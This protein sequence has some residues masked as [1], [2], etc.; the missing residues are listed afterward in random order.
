MLMRIDGIQKDLATGRSR[1]EE[2]DGVLLNVRNEQYGVEIHAT[3]VPLYC[4]SCERQLSHLYYAPGS[5]YGLV[6]YTECDHC[7]ADMSVCDNDYYV[8]YHDVATKKGNLRQDYVALYRLGKDVWTAIKQK[9]GYDIIARY[10]EQKVLLSQVISEICA[11]S[12]L[13]P[14]RLDKAQ[15]FTDPRFDRYPIVVNRWL[16][17]LHRLRI[18]M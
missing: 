13:D 10:R 7:G 1:E 14:A 5:R 15:Y 18:G 2:F 17:L 6:G 4:T 9:T 16:G 12:G 8:S 11:P 3:V